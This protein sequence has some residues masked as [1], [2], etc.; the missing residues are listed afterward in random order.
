[1]SPTF[2][3]SYQVLQREVLDLR[4]LSLHSYLPR[5][6]NEPLLWLQGWKWKYAT[7][8]NT[9]CYR[10]VRWKHCPVIKPAGQKRWSLYFLIAC[11]ADRIENLEKLENAYKDLFSRLNLALLEDVGKSFHIL[12][13][14]QNLAHEL[15]KTV[16]DVEESEEDLQQYTGSRNATMI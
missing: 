7:E 13:H 11:R 2:T 5:V 4:L 10:T 16:L 8:R 14:S 1:M 15:M 6:L 3:N 12:K 9:S